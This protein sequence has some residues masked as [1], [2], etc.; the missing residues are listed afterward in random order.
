MSYYFFFFLD[1]DL[2]E[3]LENSLAIFLLKIVYHTIYACDTFTLSYGI[4]SLRKCLVLDHSS[5][6]RTQSAVFQ[7]L[8]ISK[9]LHT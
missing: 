9:A 6:L 1:W 8:Q 4:Q 7:A 2:Q 5:S 3:V